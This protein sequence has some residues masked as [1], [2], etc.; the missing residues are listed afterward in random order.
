MKVEDSL[1]EV[2][3]GSI[4]TKDLITMRSSFPGNKETYKVPVAIAFNVGDAIAYH[5]VETHNA[6]V[7]WERE[8]PVKHYIDG[9]RIYPNKE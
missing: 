2:R 1:W 3:D 7:E 4:F 5:I 9:A 8:N 6:R